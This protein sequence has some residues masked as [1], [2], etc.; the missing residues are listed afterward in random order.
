[1]NLTDLITAYGDTWTI[2]TWPQPGATRKQQIGQVDG[3]GRA[4]TPAGL[5][6]N[7]WAIDLVDLAQQLAEQTPGV[8]TPD[9]GAGMITPPLP[10]AGKSPRTTTPTRSEP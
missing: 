3:E 7:I 1:M 5:T 6:M 8:D 4:Y 9:R 2:R 10:G